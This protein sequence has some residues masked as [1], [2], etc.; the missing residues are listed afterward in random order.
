MVLVTFNVTFESDSQLHGNL[1]FL[2]VEYRLLHLL[3]TSPT[4]RYYTNEVCR[5]YEIMFLEPL[6]FKPLGYNNLIDLISDMPTMTR[7]YDNNNI[8]PNGNRWYL[9]RSMNE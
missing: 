6:L 8:G 1:V 4:G 3:D 7:V 5:V 2:L 9:Q